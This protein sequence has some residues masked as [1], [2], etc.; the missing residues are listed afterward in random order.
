MEYSNPILRILENELKDYAIDIPKP[1]HTDQIPYCGVKGEHK[2]FID[3]G[4]CMNE[5]E[6]IVK[7]IPKFKELQ[8]KLTQL[9]KLQ[10]KTEY[11]KK[12][13]GEI[14]TMP[15]ETPALDSLF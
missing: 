8:S 7:D 12:M 9:R 4:G 11:A 6:W 13:S 10:A 2:W 5:E 1:S 14:P 15:V 3:N